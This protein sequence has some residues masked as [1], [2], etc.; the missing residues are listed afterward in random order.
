MLTINQH[1]KIFNEFADAHLQIKSFNYGDLSRIDLD[2]NINYPQFWLQMNKISVEEGEQR[3]EFRFI[4]VDC[5]KDDLQRGEKEIQS[6]MMQI[7]LDLLSVIKNGPL[8]SIYEIENIG[9]IYPFVE[10]YQNNLS[11]VYLDVILTVKYTFDACNLPI[12]N[13]P[14]IS[15]DTN[16]IIII[17]P[18]VF[19]TSATLSGTTAIFTRNDGN[20]YDL[21]LS[22]FAGGET[23]IR[24]HD[25]TG[26]TITSTSYCGTAPDGSLEN[27]PFWYITKIDIPLSG[28]G[29]TSL[30]ASGVTWTGRYTHI[31]T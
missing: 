11:G 4:F 21:D 19:T 26:D 13:F 12:E 22:Q 28:S 10:R 2:K 27:Q 23:F 18:D 3:I 9:Q 1:I 16:G 25:F 14:V 5:P 15:G 20:T 8:N 29:T 17:R 30:F 31:Y 7:A 24:R 6:D